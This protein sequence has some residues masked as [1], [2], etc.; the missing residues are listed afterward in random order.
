MLDGRAGRLARGDRASSAGPTPAQHLRLRC[1]RASTQPVFAAQLLDV[2]AEHNARARIEAAE[3]LTSATLDTTPC[4]ILVT[5]LEGTVIRVNAAATRPD[6]LHRGRARRSR[7]AWTHLVAPERVHLVPETCSATAPLLPSG[8]GRPTCAPSTATRSGWCG[9]TRSSPDDDGHPAYVVLT[10]IDVTAERTAAGLV[11]HLLQASITTAL[12]GIDRRG[13]ITLFN[14]GAQRLLGLRGRRGGRPPVHRPARPRRAGDPDE[15]RA[16][17]PALS[18]R[19]SQTSATQRREPAAGLDLAG[20]AAADADGV[21]DPERG[22][23]TPPAHRTASSAWDVTS[24]S[25]GTAR[26]C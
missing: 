12:I 15:R 18:R 7:P 16:R 1:S 17:S 10:G 8:R 19:S 21:D 24:P 23:A 22:G 6:R 14:S 4:I 20:G 2:T 9:T 11:N 26:R 5:D 25:S 3:K 13:R